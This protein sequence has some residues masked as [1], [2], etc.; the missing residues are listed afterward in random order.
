M[1][2]GHDAA[3]AHVGVDVVKVVEY[4]R[5]EDLR[6]VAPGRA[7]PVPTDMRRGAGRVVVADHSNELV[8]KRRAISPVMAL[9]LSGLGPSRRTE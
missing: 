1:A 6:R 9:K 5:L 2:P 4:F 8:R 3:T 7:V